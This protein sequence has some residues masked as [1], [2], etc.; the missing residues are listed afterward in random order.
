[1]SEEVFDAVVA[2]ERIALH[3]EEEVVRG[4]GWECLEPEMLAERWQ[5]LKRKGVAVS[6]LHLK[7]SLLAKAGERHFV[8]SMDRLV[9]RTGA[10]L[11][12]GLDPGQVQTARLVSPH[13]GHKAKM[14]VL[15]TARF[16]D[17]NPAA[18]AAVVDR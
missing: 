17:I 9:D 16:A 4:W 6:L 7:P 18:D 2:D 5:H 12:Q 11:G 15:A 10:Q 13:A 1:N 8:D 3:I 14:V